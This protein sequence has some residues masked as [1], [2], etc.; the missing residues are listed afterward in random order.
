MAG[1]GE[2]SIA[3]SADRSS[4]RPWTPESRGDR[5][6]GLAERRKIAEIKTKHVPQLQQELNEAVGFALPFEI[7][8]ASFPEDKDV[9]AGY[10][11]YYED[12]GPAALVRAMRELCCDDLGK[13]ALQAKVKQIVFQNV[14][15]NKDTS[16]EKE[17][18]LENGVLYIRAGF[19]GY[20]DKLFQEDELRIAFEN[21]L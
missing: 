6:M 21:M 12:R 8:V 2:A 1:K 5:I 16:G 15:V 3:S 19:Y 18:K 7:D 14:G 13:E 17:L 10:E 11:Y 9:L 4:E 20:G